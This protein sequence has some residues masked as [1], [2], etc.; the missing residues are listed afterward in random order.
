ML[1]SLKIPMPILIK[2][3]RFIITPNDILQNKDILIMDDKI[4]SIDGKDKSDFVIDASNKVVMP[5][6]I[7]SHTH[8]A[9]TLLRG[10]GD[11]MHLMEW[12]EKKIWPIE[13]KMT[14]EDCYIGSLLGCLESIRFGVTT[15]SDMYY[16]LD[17]T[18]KACLESGV[19]GVLSWAILDEAFTTQK[20]I[21]LDNAKNFIE[22]Y[23]GYELVKPSLGPHSIYTCSKETLIKT[24][25]L[26]DKYNSLMHMHVSETKDEVE[27][28]IKKFGKRPVEFLNEIGFLS[29]KLT[30]AHCVHLS[31]KE[32]EMI[33]ENNVKV[34]HC[35]IS[36]LKLAS[37]I[38]PIPEML[39]KEITIGLGTDSSASNNNLDVFE[40]MKTAALIHKG[41][42]N[43]ATLVSAKQALDMATKNGGLALGL[44]VGAIEV[45][46]K[47]D[48]ILIDLKK[49]H[50]Q[51]IHSIISNLV[52]STKGSDVDT[53]ICNGKILM[54]NRKVLTLNEEE[55][56][57]KAQN[58]AERLRS[59]A[60]EEKL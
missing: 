1:K 13:S 57:E 17:E 14:S 10:Y 22:K 55:I 40:E 59:E 35:P 6:L 4:V 46:K 38:A 5:G 45:G 60:K 44:D 8:L 42:K 56:Y 2:N 30:A 26:S 52:Y 20:G 37:G 53:V 11:D 50:L 9:M 16:F 41:F 39:K 28:S 54:E 7:N 51:P 12:L 24:K 34:L 31:E 3:A 43:N 19:R 32:I 47:A 48:L 58:S 23:S 21:P 33:K 36:N 15:F 18:A 49:P 27:T 29:P 25:E